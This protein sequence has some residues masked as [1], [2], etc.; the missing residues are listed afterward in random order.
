[1]QVP[2]ECATSD[3]L[4]AWAR[5]VSALSSRVGMQATA[6]QG[7]SGKVGGKAGATLWSSPSATK[8]K[9]A[10]GQVEAGVG[11]A[12]GQLQALADELRRVAADLGEAALRAQAREREVERRAD[13]AAREA[14]RQ[15]DRVKP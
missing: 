15:A 8:L 12:G 4:R 6:V 9:G 11:R 10:I 13:E 2:V 1:V 14:Q 5:N 3:Q 7:L